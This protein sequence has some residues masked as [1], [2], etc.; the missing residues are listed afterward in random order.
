MFNTYF[1]VGMDGRAGE[2]PTVPPDEGNIKQFWEDRHFL[3][4]QIAFT[5]DHG[6]GGRQFKYTYFVFGKSGM[7]GENGKNGGSPG[8]HAV[9]G[10]LNAIFINHKNRTNFNTIQK[11]K[12]NNR[13]S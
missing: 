13:H 6:I 10:H 1:R 4:K 9:D 2:D 7:V 11:K 8:L 5:N 3:F 12:R